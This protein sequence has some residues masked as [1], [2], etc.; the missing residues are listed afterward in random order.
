MDTLI[1]LEHEI[2]MG[3]VCTVTQRVGIEMSGRI[4]LIRRYVVGVTSGDVPSNTVKRTRA[5]GLS[6]FSL[7][8]FLSFCLS[9]SLSVSVWYGIRHDGQASALR[10][11]PAVCPPL[12][13][14]PTD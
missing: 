8:F 4:C 7:C 6:S 11:V 3:N 10:P 5:V 14:M 13:V 2:F 1:G 9:V 12:P